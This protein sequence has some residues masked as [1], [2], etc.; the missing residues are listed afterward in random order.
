MKKKGGRGSKVAFLFSPTRVK[1][2]RTFLFCPVLSSSLCPI[3]ERNS[4]CPQTKAHQDAASV[5]MER[6]RW[7]P[8]EFIR[9][10]TR[11][12]ENGSTKKKKRNKKKTKE[13][14]DRYKREQKAR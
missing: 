12:G 2:K 13:I 7:E 3:G 9:L 6:S 5:W 8:P 4:I 14:N 10:V 11:N 1:K